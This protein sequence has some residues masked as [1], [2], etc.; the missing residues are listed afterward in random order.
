MKA[1]TWQKWGP[2]CIKIESDRTFTSALRSNDIYKILHCYI[3]PSFLPHKWPAIVQKKTFM[4]RVKQ[5]RSNQIGIQGWERY[6][7]TAAMCIN[8]FNFHKINLMDRDIGKQE[9]YA[10]AN[11]LCERNNCWRIIFGKMKNQLSHCIIKPQWVTNAIKHRNVN[12]NK[13][14]EQT[15][16]YLQCSFI[17]SLQ[18]HSMSLSLKRSFSR[19]F[20]PL[21]TNWPQ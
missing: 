18:P 7:A 16:T 8:T 6:E 1:K 20:S 19:S 4:C 5:Q 12:S 21:S 17:S 14:D 13:I 10:T 11:S 9:T 15:S 3:I 2:T